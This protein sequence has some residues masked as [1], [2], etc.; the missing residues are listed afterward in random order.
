MFCTVGAGKGQCGFQGLLLRS[1]AGSKQPNKDYKNS[2]LKYRFHT[3]F[4]PFLFSIFH[5]EQNLR[6]EGLLLIQR[7]KIYGYIQILRF[8]SLK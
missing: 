7:R 3:S 5:T 6:S 8:I 4:L 2:N 1:G